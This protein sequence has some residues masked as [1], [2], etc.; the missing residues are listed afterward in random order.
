MSEDVISFVMD[1][2]IEWGFDPCWL[3][4][5]NTNKVKQEEKHMQLKLQR[6]FNHKDAQAPRWQRRLRRTGS[7][8]SAQEHVEDPIAVGSCGETEDHSD[9]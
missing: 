3:Q 7:V 6:L 5:A 8:E 2:A 4:A 1:H 9:S